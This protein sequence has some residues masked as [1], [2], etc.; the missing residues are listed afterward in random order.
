MVTLVSYTMFLIYQ[1]PSQSPRLLSLEKHSIEMVQFNEK[2][3]DYQL[4]SD[5]QNFNSA[6]K[7][8]QEKLNAASREYMGLEVS[9]VDLIDGHYPFR[10]SQELVEKFDL[11]PLSICNFVH[12]IPLHMQKISQT[13]KFGLFAEKYSQY[14][15]ELYIIDERNYLSSVHYGLA[16][17]NG[18]G[19]RASTYFHLSSCTDEVTDTE[20][21]FLRCS[22][23]N[24]GYAFSTFNR[25]DI[26]SS[27]SGD[28][29]CRIN[30]DPWRQSLFEYGETLREQRRQL[31]T[32]FMPES[33]DHEYHMRSFLEIHR[34]SELENIVGNMVH[35]K[36]DE[37]D[38][39]DM[40]KRYEG[41]YGSM[42][43]ELLELISDMP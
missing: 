26:I 5:T 33:A 13:E 41:Q 15:I 43:E 19:Q 37:Q 42:P 38:T 2:S 3:R 9:S 16:A 22:D 30:L 25:D 21:Y 18:E 4:A 23:E 35:G 27:L 6:K 1:D 14:E 34:Q 36:F 24:D 20:P 28:H 11:D 32:E 29:F 10:D 8:M 40:I 7:S 39:Q 17:T 12:K 31:Q